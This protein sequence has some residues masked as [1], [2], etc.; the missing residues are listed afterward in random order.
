MEFLGYIKKVPGIKESKKWEYVELQFPN[1]GLFNDC[2]SRIFKGIKNNES[3]FVVADSEN[4][5]YLLELL[6]IRYNA[7]KL[8][9]R[10]WPHSFWKPKK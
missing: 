8:T 1:E 10:I 2:T 3:K 5:R 6:D 4:D 9:I 7:Q